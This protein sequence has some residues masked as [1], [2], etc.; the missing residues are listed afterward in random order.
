MSALLPL[1]ISLAIAGNEAFYGPPSPRHTMKINV[2][3]PPLG[4][5]HQKLRHSPAFRKCEAQII[6]GQMVKSYNWSPKGFSMTLDEGPQAQTSVSETFFPTPA[7]LGKV[8]ELEGQSFRLQN[9]GTLISRADLPLLDKAYQRVKPASGHASLELEF[10]GKKH[11]AEA[12][13]QS[14]REEVVRVV[15]ERYLAEK[16]YLKEEDFEHLRFNDLIIHPSQFLVLLK[17]EA[18]LTSITDLRSRL[19]GSIRMDYLEDI[20]THMPPSLYE[21]FLTSHPLSWGSF[22]NRVHASPIKEGLMEAFYE[23][24]GG[25]FTA[26]ITRFTYFDRKLPTAIKSRFLLEIL[27]LASHPGFQIE[28]LV[29]TGDQKT[30]RLFR[31][32]SM[33]QIFEGP[34]RPDGENESLHVAY[35]Y[36]RNFEK[37]T[38]S[39]RHKSRG[40]KVQAAVKPTAKPAETEASKP[41]P[42]ANEGP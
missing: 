30:A 37:F 25:L 42:S 13:L 39:L 33:K 4:V 6:F 32:F 10:T 27:H 18:P 29:A 21:R 38:A 1:L 24:V 14:F 11:S 26:E 40:V 23:A 20:N 34:F 41:D 17:G 7:Y 9:I 19:M 28:A 15:Y 8:L 35:P 2:Q 5:E 36:S 31:L 22:E 16:P 3:H 12:W